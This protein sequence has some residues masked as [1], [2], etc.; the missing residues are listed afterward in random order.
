[1]FR[2][3]RGLEVTAASEEAVG[4]LDATIRSFLGFRL[5][6]GEHLKRTLAA[7]PEMPLAL[8][9]R[10]CFMHLFGQPALLPKARACWEAA[11]AAAEARGAGERE[12]G[13]VEALGAW[14]Q[15]D[16]DTAA[17]H[18]DAILLRWPQDLLALRLS[19]FRHFYSGDGRRMRDAAARAVLR[20]DP[21]MPD[22]GFALGVLAFACEEAGLYREAETYGRRAVAAN[23]A[24]IWSTHAVAHVLE[25]E[26][27]HRDGIAWLGSL[28]AHWDGI[29][30]F[31][32]HAWWHKAL[33]HLELG[34]HDAVLDLYDN[35]FRA[36][37]NDEYLD[38]TNA[39]A[40]LWRL[41][42]RGVGVGG[43][44]TELAER[45]A[46]RIRD[47]YLVFADVHYA[48]A[49]AATGRVE[50]LELLEEAM[51]EASEGDD[52]QAAIGTEVGVPLVQAIGAWRAGD[53]RQARDLLLDVRY[54]IARIGGS[55]AQRDLFHEMLVTAA[56][57]AGDDPV[58]ALSLTAERICARPHNG[59][60]WECHARALAATG[61]DA[62]AAR[63]RERA[64]AA[65]A[66]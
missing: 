29:N 37:P 18:W 50:E 11:R 40:M 34:E 5:D 24:D 61:D 48:M 9:V 3:V 23:P 42:H 6:T 53:H 47:H 55:H 17:R 49:L 15:G 21:G 32:N 4:H 19:H 36:V 65:R 1:M 64:A 38:I 30:P 43:R 22:H 46:T 56:L 57:A 10:G 35:R 26:G 52:W 58:L 2:D 59:F 31:V 16:L 63:A 62:A 8:A 14:C 39:T 45:S 66:G 27:R 60:A 44:W 20:L 54:G 28:S 13:H 33:Y 7:D 41:E 25:M 51:R 12:R